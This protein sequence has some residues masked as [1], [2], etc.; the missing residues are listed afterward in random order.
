MPLLVLGLN[1]KTAPVGLLERVAVAPEGVPKALASLAQR[2][3]VREAAVLSTCN[4]V[5]VYASVSRFHGGMADLRR[6]FAEWGGVAPEDFVDLAYD[7]YDDKAARHLFSVT[8]GLDSMVVGERQI[9]LQVKQAFAD[10]EAEGTAG[11]ML[12]SLFRRALRVGKRARRETAISA[13]A[14]SMVDVGLDAAR[15]VLGH[16]DGSTV[17]VVGAGK[18]GGMGADRLSGVAARILVANRTPDRA[19]R[20][21]ARVDGEVVALG[22]LADGLAVADLVLCSTGASTPVVDHDTVAEAMR[23]RPERPLVLV[24]LAVPRDVDAACAGLPSVSVLDI[25]AI[26]TLTDG[27]GSVP[28]GGA[29]GGLGAEVERGRAIVEEEA[30]RFAA[31][32]RSVRVEPT[33]AALRGRAEQVRVAELG[34]L[35][36]RLA[37]L[38]ERER[39]AVD[40]LTRGIVNTLL[41]EPTIRLKALADRSGD[42]HAAALREL[43]DLP[44]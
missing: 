44:E 21:A 33:V 32:T 31:W 23:R 13:G 41:H 40:A 2:E 16:L 27:G 6:F 8:A 26:R 28:A 29:P 14:S 1:Y 42:A 11:R 30:E 3:H 10:A 12:S 5:E 22:R 38:D 34:R 20:L 43:F 37:D 15:R 24:D 7:H 9:Q 36:P 17:L 39:A 35:A 4:R 19:E 18:M 25:D